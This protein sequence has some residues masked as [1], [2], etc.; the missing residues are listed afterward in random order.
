MIRPVETLSDDAL[1]YLKKTVGSE[2]ASVNQ[3]DREHHAKDQSFHEPHLPAAVVFPESTAQVS[4]ILKYANQHLIP[5]TG[6][7]AG[8]SL[9][10]HTIPVAGGIVIDFM[11]MDKIL[12]V[13]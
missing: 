5:I 11:R 10:G 1:E 2:F 6:F 7:G 13:Y 9:E 8:T 3:S 12:R 4:A